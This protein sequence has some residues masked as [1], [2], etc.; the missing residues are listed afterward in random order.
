MREKM[1]ITNTHDSVV[2]L[3]CKNKC[4]IVVFRKLNFLSL[5][6]LIY[7]FHLVR[8]TSWFGIAL[9]QFLNSFINEYIRRHFSFNELVILL[10]SLGNSKFISNLKNFVHWSTT[11]WNTRVNLN[12]MWLFV[13]VLIRVFVCLIYIHKLW[14]YISHERFYLP[15]FAVWVMCYNTSNISYCCWVTLLLLFA[16]LQLFCQVLFSLIFTVSLIVYLGNACH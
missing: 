2:G 16:S 10:D 11:V 13:D 1:T 14:F 8:M 6:D 15:E 4:V 12:F 9:C 7:R 3:K 5:I